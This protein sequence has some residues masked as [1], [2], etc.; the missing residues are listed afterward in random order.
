M[1]KRKQS[2]PRRSD[3]IIGHSV[4]NSNQEEPAASTDCPDAGVDDE[5][6]ERKKV[7]FVEVDTNSSPSDKHFNVADIRVCDVRFSEGLSSA[8]FVRE[9]FCEA[10]FALRFRVL[11]EP[12]E[13]VHVGNWPMLSAGNVYLEFVVRREDDSEGSVVFSAGFDASDEGITGLVHLVS[14]KFLTVRLV[15]EDAV[16]EGFPSFRA[17]IDILCKAFDSCESLYE[18]TRAPW[19]KSMMNVMAWLRPEVVTSEVRYGFH[20]SE[21]I[22]PGLRFN[23]ESPFDALNFYEAISPSKQ[24]P[25][26]ADELSDLLPKLRP[27]QRRAAYWM[28]QQEKKKTQEKVIHE[29][30]DPLPNPLCIPVDAVDKSARIFYNP[31]SGSL[32]M[33]S[34]DC[35]LDISGGI[36]ADE[37][38]L[39]KTVE[40]LACIFAHRKVLINHCVA[41]KNQL[42]QSGTA[43]SKLNRLKRERVECVCGAVSESVEYRGL[44]VQCD[45]C[46]AWQHA[47]CVGFT[48]AN[49]ISRT[50]GCQPSPA[51]GSH[52]NVKKKGQL[53]VDGSYVCTTCIELIQASNCSDVSGATLIVCPSPILPQWQEE[54]ARH[55]RAGSLKVHVYEGVKNMSSCS[56]FIDLEELASA[57]IVLTT[58][59]VLK[60]DLS[61]DHDRHGGDRRVMRFRKRYPVVPTP[62]TRIF[63]WRI[64]LDEAQ[65]V[66]STAASATEMALRLRGQHHWCITG[67][68]IQRSLDDMHGLLRFLRASPFDLH[69]WWIEVIRDPYEG[70]DVAAMEFTYNLFRKIM[71]RS[72]KVLVADEL[73][74]PPQEEHISWLFFSP[75][76]AHFYQRQHET[77]SSYAHKVLETFKDEMQKRKMTHGSDVPCELFLSHA[78]VANLLGSLLKLR[79]ACCH[80][81]VGSS[82]LRSLQQ[83]PMTMEDILGVLIGKTK[84]EGE[85]ALR[86]LVVALNG[87]A[88]IAVLEKDYQHG[89][90]LYN[91]ALVLAEESS[92]DFRLDP[93]L[94][95]H[96]L[97]NL[98]EIVQIVPH[99]LQKCLESGGRSSKI[100]KSS[101][102]LSEVSECEPHSAKRQKLSDDCSNGLNQSSCCEVRTSPS[103]SLTIVPECQE[104]MGH[105]SGC[106]FLPRP[107]I[108]S[109]LLVECEHITNKYLAVFVS[110]LSVARQEFK[111]SYEQV[112]K[113]L[114]ECEHE[115]ST[116]WIEALD[117]VEQK[118]HEEELIKKITEGVAGVINGSKSSKISSRF[119]TLSGLKYLIQTGLDSLRTC[120]NELLSRLMEIDL[121]MD[122][123]RAVDVERVRYCSNCQPNGN[124][125]LCVQCEADE[126]F[127]AYEARLFLLTKGDNIASA[128]EALDLRKHKSAL[129]R[130]FGDL[131]QGDKNIHGS[132]VGK[133]EKRH[134]EAKSSVV[135]S[136]SPSEVELILSILRSF[137]KSR[138]GKDVVA[139]ASKHLLLL[140]ALRR[141]FS[142][143]RSFSIAQAQILRAHDEIKMA[144]S[145]LRL[146]ETKDEVSTIDVLSPEELI[147]S[148]MHFSSEKFMSLS[149]LSRVKGHLRYL[150]GLAVAKQRKKDEGSSPSSSN[151]HLGISA[152]GSQVKAEKVECT[153]KGE[154]ESCP[155]CHEKLSNQKMVFQCGH[156]TCCQC[157]IAMTEHAFVLHGKTQRKWVMCPK[158]REHTHYENIAYV[159]DDRNQAYDAVHIEGSYGTK[160]IG[161]VTKKIMW[162][163]S[164][165]PQAKILVFSSW[166]D[167]LDV[168]GHSLDANG[169][170]YVRMKGGRKSHTALK[171][172]REGVTRDTDNPIAEINQ[173]KAK[174]IRVLLILI[175]HGA[176]GLN[177]L[178]AQHVVLIEPLLNPAVEAQA[179][180]RVH[181][182]GQEKPTFVHRFIVK[183]T[184]E[185]SIHKL[186]IS[187][188]A[189]SVINA[190]RR[191]QD[192]PTLTVQDL[193]S[194][195]CS[196][197]PAETGEDMSSA[198]RQT[199][200]LRHLPPA[201]AAAL[202][203][204][205]RQRQGQQTT[206]ESYE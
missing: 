191:S 70:K 97:H 194:L 169:I 146:R 196:G 89:I 177:L 79:Q 64:C 195:F 118:G 125:P 135:I 43:I 190:V 110:K 55:T 57:D 200:C 96:I 8:E 1:G 192:Q 76:E 34:E 82:G 78:E 197:K 129:N 77:C 147:S 5:N 131:A 109:N 56:S 40:L 49:R 107:I 29:K 178:E 83:T 154:D 25:M 51:I 74:L 153:D 11:M 87:L 4:P 17:R 35:S 141:E 88:G 126:L 80:P 58:Y 119:R 101:A 121:T 103:D 155:V 205:N 7:V 112:G 140:E 181:R 164:T 73:Q 65:M 2:K 111:N 186:N 176:N 206:C 27:Y 151:E 69:R 46:D 142:Q 143:A 156:V 150:K 31:F 173:C 75:I 203:A 18:T 94:N 28:I 139:S 90:S 145:R 132:N 24:E 198:I 149:M 161:A 38:G 15:M 95:L 10:D 113:L 3:G 130:F 152:G 22:Q 144:T 182:I 6:F 37:M 171:E 158:C 30:S 23:K 86:R 91:E 67:T 47:D 133:E 160:V 167:V 53:D 185:E 14:Q 21:F 63:W 81:Q 202:A 187:K 162:I 44:W 100:F 12:G 157:L 45:V 66:E 127:M 117:L 13:S 60:E 41:P 52:N 170:T 116:W 138:L 124:G 114:T 166:N 106:G 172:F 168:L 159:D 84:T 136:R 61:H 72:S 59:D 50:R 204:E 39:G 183:N 128:E 32:S 105:Q 62:L 179:I 193:E 93:L 189:T 122:S 201:V 85:E 137:S 188:A 175:Q 9:R 165:D 98:A 108:I 20:K 180:N 134:R 148:N 99:C 48:G 68:P 115:H 92:D 71:W 163:L 199:E 19:K 123:P 184:V 26:L 36:L 104:F 174:S 42:K 33:D 54:I 102:K 16:S 120:R